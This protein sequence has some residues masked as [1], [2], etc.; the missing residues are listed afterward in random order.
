MKMQQAGRWPK[1]A[2]PNQAWKAATICLGGAEGELEGGQNPLH[3]TR[4]SWHGLSRQQTNQAFGSRKPS[5]G[6][7]NRGRRGAEGA[8]GK[9]FRNHSSMTDASQGMEVV[10]KK[11][12]QGRGKA[13]PSVGE[14][15]G[16]NGK[17]SKPGIMTRG[18]QGMEVSRQQTNQVLESRSTHLS[19]E[20]QRVNVEGGKTRQQDRASRAWRCQGSKTTRAWKAATTVGG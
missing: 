19:G 10:G 15:Q 1:A 3:M 6:E 18:K 12:N 9:G 4:A 7:I 16:G 8:T 5:A 20:D 11:T 2:R 13:A 14:E 17:G